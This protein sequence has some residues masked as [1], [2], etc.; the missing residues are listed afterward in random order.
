M[1]G[2]RHID[3]IC[4][5]VTALTLILTLC[6]MQGEALGL[7]PASTAY[8]YSSLLFDQT[9]VH[10]IEI[11]AE[12]WEQMLQE[13]KA[14]QYIPADITI[15]GEKIENV[16]IRTK[17]AN[18]LHLTEKYGLERYSYKIE[19]D[20]YEPN[21]YHGLDKLSLDASFQDNAYMKTFLTFD[22]MRHMGVATP[23]CSY[24]QVKV[25][26]EQIGLY[27]AIEEIEESFARRN[28]GKNHG[29]LYKAEYRSTETANED[30]GL[31]YHGEDFSYYQKLFENAKFP[32]TD[33]DKR[34]LIDALQTLSTG[35]NLASAV[36]IDAM[37]RYF[38][39]QVF[40][41]NLDSYL[42]KNGH[43][44][45]LYEKDGQISMLPWDYN[46]A[47]GTYSLGMPN[48]INDPTLYI[49]YPIDTPASGEVM[50]NRLLYHN[51][52]QHDDC[53][54]Q[55]H[56]YFDQFITE[57]FESGYFTALVASIDNMIAPCVQADPTAFCSYDDYRLAVKTLTDFCLLR[58]ES[59]RGQLDGTIPSTIKGQSIDP[60]GFIDGSSIRLEDLGE[61]EDLKNG[62]H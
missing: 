51:L 15:D 17:G 22:M 48:P 13:P 32:I 41:V 2:H 42:G 44:Y 37:L 12:D 46:L 24:T 29:K 52:M 21:S 40:V 27:L 58:A 55:Y 31:L 20:H 19:F 35:E 23:L 49:N 28:Y 53:F 11:T 45:Y 25:N 9:K 10:T 3:K 38:T 6:F 39:V 4:I 8:A 1:L 56:S 26:G 33:A 54:A 18:S 57:Y 7:M 59:V 47:F 30:V 34:R 14:E 62:T 36:D 60:T 16:G 61:V 43:N 50:I 5:L